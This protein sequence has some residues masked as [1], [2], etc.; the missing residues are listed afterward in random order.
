M[1]TNRSSE[2]MADLMLSD[3]DDLLCLKDTALKLVENSALDRFTVQHPMQNAQS[4]ESRSVP[5]AARFMSLDRVAF[6]GSLSSH[7]S[8]MMGRHAEDSPSIPPLTAFRVVRRR[9][10]LYQARR[11]LFRMMFC[12]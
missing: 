11:R 1:R 9:H 4:G 3:N 7:S 2:Q 12:G 10:V 8:I 6:A 5:P